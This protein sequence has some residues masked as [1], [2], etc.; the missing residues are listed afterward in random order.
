MKKVIVIKVYLVGIG[1]VPF[2]P[3]YKRKRKGRITALVV[4]VVVVVVVEV[5]V[6]VASSSG[7]VAAAAVVV[8]LSLSSS[9]SLLALLLQL[10]LPLLPTLPPLLWLC[11]R[12]KWFHTFQTDIGVPLKYRWL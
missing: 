5:G 6:I 4:V 11:S 12:L 1:K 2:M 3:S 9:S 7:I 10:P 8:L